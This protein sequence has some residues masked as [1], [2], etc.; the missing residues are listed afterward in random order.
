MGAVISLDKYREK[1]EQKTTDAVKQRYRDS[2]D[3]N[4]VK[5]N[6]KL[7]EDSPQ[8]QERIKKIKA[9]IERINKLMD[10]GSKQ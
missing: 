8:I 6:Y 9:S 10:E 5:Q 4:K 7:G 2:L 3:N 1:K